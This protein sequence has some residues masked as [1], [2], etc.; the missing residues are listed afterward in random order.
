MSSKKHIGKDNMFKGFDL[1]PFKKIVPP[2]NDSKKTKE[3]LKYIGNIKLD[4][5]FF[6]E[7]DD[8]LGNFLK[9]LDSKKIEYDKKELKKIISDAVGVILELKEYFKRPRPFKIE[10]KFSDPEI[11]STKGYSYP[12][13]HSTQS[14]LISLVLSKKF[15]KYKKEFDEITKDI[16]FSR[17]MAKVHYPSDI[18]FGEKLAKELFNYLNDNNEIKGNLRESIRRI[19]TE[20]TSSSIR[21]RRKF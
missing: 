17:Q 4:K 13:G 2:K 5:R 15:P 10:P 19:I 11:E 6:Q 12:S 9:F 3:E 20:E 14:N 21:F 7:K 8:I 1:E 18:K 16:V